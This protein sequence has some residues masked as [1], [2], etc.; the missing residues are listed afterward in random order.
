MPMFQV[1]IE[2]KEGHRLFKENFWENNF[3][4]ISLAKT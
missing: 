1:E 3:I 4:Y 2:K